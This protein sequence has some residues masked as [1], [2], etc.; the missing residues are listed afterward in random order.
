[1][2]LF[3]IGFGAVSDAQRETQQV[4]DP[5]NVRGSIMMAPAL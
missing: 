5:F 2:P 1:M 4:A 3:H